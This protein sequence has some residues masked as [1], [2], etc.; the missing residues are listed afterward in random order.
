M[1][2][3]EYKTPRA[4]RR[5]YLKMARAFEA[6]SRMKDIEKASKYLLKTLL[7]NK[8]SKTPNLASKM[9][10]TCNCFHLGYSSVHFFPEFRIFRPMI[11]ERDVF[12]KGFETKS[13]W[14]DETL[15]GLAERALV[16]YFAAEMCK[17]ERK[18]KKSLEVTN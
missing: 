14:W 3:E 7:N 1:E 10:F 4:R 12:C 9:C 11:E 15:E 8:I 2:Q 5:I 17:P 16:L 13:Y 6:A 18:S